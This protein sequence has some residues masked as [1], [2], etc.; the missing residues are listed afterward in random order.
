MSGMI[1]I[2]WQLKTWSGVGK[3][4]TCVRLSVLMIMHFPRACGVFFLICRK[5]RCDVGVETRAR[6]GARSVFHVSLSAMM[7]RT[8]TCSLE[9]S[10]FLFGGEIAFSARPFF[11]STV[12]AFIADGLLECGLSRM[13]AFLGDIVEAEIAGRTVHEGVAFAVRPDRNHSE[14]FPAMAQD[15]FHVN[16]FWSCVSLALCSPALKFLLGEVRLSDNFG[17]L[18]RNLF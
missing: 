1:L 7:S 10:V 14:A 11:S 12:T 5:I 16:G 18:T 17:S 4:R 8:R 9:E 15:S 3:N 6:F 13:P 2:I